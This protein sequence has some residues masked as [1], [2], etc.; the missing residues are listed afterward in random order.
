MSDIS[1]TRKTSICA[2]ACD[3]RGRTIRFVP[4]AEVVHIAAALP[5]VIRKPSRCAGAARFAYYRKHHPAMGAATDA[6]SPPDGKHPSEEHRIAFW[7]CDPQYSVAA[8]QPRASASP[9]R[10]LMRIAI[11]ARKLHDFGIGTYIRNVLRGLAR[12]DRTTEYVVFCRPA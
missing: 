5:S 1:C 7:E 6:L 3:N 8:C 2:F 4:E 12:M 9:A 11:D 10:F